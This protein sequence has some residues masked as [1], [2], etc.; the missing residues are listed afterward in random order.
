MTPHQE[1]QAHEEGPAGRDRGRRPRRT[2]G[3][4]GAIAALIVG[5][6]GLLA[7]GAALIGA[8]RRPAQA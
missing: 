1:A 7:G 8:R 5:G 6:L 3:G 4:A 2:R